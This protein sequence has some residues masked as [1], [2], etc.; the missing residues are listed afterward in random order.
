MTSSPPSDAPKLSCK[1]RD[2][3][4]VGWWGSSGEAQQLPLRLSLGQKRSSPHMDTTKPG[5]DPALFPLTTV[6]VGNWGKLEHQHQG[7]LRSR[8][9][10]CPQKGWGVGLQTVSGRVWRADKLQP[11]QTDLEALPDPV[12]RYTCDLCT[13]DGRPHFHPPSLPSHRGRGRAVLGLVFL[14]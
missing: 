10:G 5:A 7:R 4:M 9:G 14:S 12:F 8:L 6:Y 2:G 13:C 3:G 11:Q 1:G